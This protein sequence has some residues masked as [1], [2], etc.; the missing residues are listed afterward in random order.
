MVINIRS[1][2]VV[3]YLKDG[4]L[5]FFVLNDS[6]QLH[7]LAW[8]YVLSACHCPPPI[9][10]LNLNS[11]ISPCTMLFS[12][13]SSL[14]LCASQIWVYSIVWLH[15]MACY[16]QYLLIF[17]YKLCN[18]ITCDSAISHCIS[19]PSSLSNTVT[20]HKFNDI[21]PRD[22]LSQLSNIVFLRFSF[23]S[24]LNCVTTPYDLL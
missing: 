10:Q 16:I 12:P 15:E 17:C 9:L 4:R 3:T 21:T 23:M 6:I 19:I 2:L 18:T 13:R 11:T 24:I 8:H 5:I 7:A 22:V 20:T 14:C 1:Q